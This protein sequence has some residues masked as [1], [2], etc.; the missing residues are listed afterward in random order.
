MNYEL[1]KIEYKGF[2]IRIVNDECPEEPDWGDDE[3]F[4]TTL[5]RSGYSFGRGEAPDPEQFLAWGEGKWGEYG[6]EGPKPPSSGS[7]SEAYDLYELW[8]EER[9][10]EYQVWPFRAGNAHGPGSFC[11]SPMDVDD[12]DRRDPDGWLYVKRLGDLESLAHPERDPEKIRDALICNYETWSN[13][14]VWGFIV[15]DQDGEG[16]DSCWGFYGDET[17]IEQAKESADHLCSQVREVM[18]LVIR[19]SPSHTW[20]TIN[21]EP[22]TAVPD[23]QVPAWAMEKVFGRDP[24]ITGAALISSFSPVP[25]RTDVEKLALTG[26]AP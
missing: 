9:S 2:T 12:L 21:V 1:E 24:T 26:E 10:D 4:L 8:Q 16:L 7:E 14:G 20:E 25:K 11:I 13:G 6:S 5:N 22:P 3:C 15:E 23:S 19:D 18:V 17:C